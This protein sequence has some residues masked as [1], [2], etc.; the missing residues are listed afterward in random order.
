MEKMNNKKK[1]VLLS[2][3]IPFHNRINLLKKTINSIKPFINSNYEI[4]LVDDGSKKNLY[5][6]LSSYIGNNIYY[7]KI[8]NAERGYARNYGAFKANGIYLNFFDSDDLALSN[9]IT[10]FENYIKK[11]K[12]PNVFS[13]SYIVKNYKKNTDKI[14]IHNGKLNKKIFFHNI[15]SCNSVFIKKEVFN[16]YK[17]CEDKNLSGSEDWDLWL[18]IASFEEI[19]GNKEVSSILIDHSLRSTRTQELNKINNRIDTLFERVQ[20]KKIFNLGSNL[21]YVK[22]EIYS[23]KALINASLIKSKL[24]SIRLLILS[25]YYRPFRIFEKRTLVILKKI[26]ID[27]I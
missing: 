6:E 10:S 19:F 15:L 2:I 11:N 13:N 27:F 9:H 20:D 3:I 17:F 14:V 7:F 5:T 12:Y 24:L 22:S 18:R 8:N 1:S 21:N 25:I 4:I 23:F 16:K 26:I